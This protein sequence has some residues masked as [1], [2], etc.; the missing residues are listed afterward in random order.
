MEELKKEFTFSALPF[1]DLSN[2]R[3]LVCTFDRFC[4]GSFNRNG[5]PVFAYAFPYCRM[6][7]WCCH[8]AFVG[9]LVFRSYL[10]AESVVIGVIVCDGFSM[11]IQKRPSPTSHTD[12]GLDLVKK[13]KSAWRFRSVPC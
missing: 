11:Q 12:K 5:S 1:L 9:V 3:V 8:K 13:G 2:R 10:H 7:N 6:L 4:Q